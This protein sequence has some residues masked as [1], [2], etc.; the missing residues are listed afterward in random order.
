MQS[1]GV[2]ISARN[3][4]LFELRTP[5]T[6]VIGEAA[7][8]N[9]QRPTEAVPAV[10]AGRALRF[11]ILNWSAWTPERETRAA[12]C[13]WAGAS[14][15][16][17][18]ATPPANLPML[19]RRR[20]SPFGQRL[21][22][23]IN[24]CAAGLPPARYVLSTRHGELARALK[25]L[26]AIEA[27]EL[28]S[29][30]DFSMSIHHALLGILSIHAGN[31]LGHTALSAGWDSFA[32][33]LLEA[34]ACIAER[35]EEPVIL[36]HAD[37][38]LPQDYDAFREA[39]DAALPLVVAIALGRP[40]GAPTNDVTLEPRSAMAERPPTACMATDFLKFLLSDAPRAHAIG[41]RAQWIWRRVA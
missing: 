6:M 8:R 39:D 26:D 13:S 3:L 27:D 19:L 5:D 1:K 15:D 23:A 22:E 10:S 18:N 32:N 33:G 38:K 29:P 41:R 31:R 37:D 9:N 34:A 40:G 12:W 14:H 25:A 36:V 17:T 16:A 21:V 2:C 24:A 11:S 35:P 20:L 7:N 30:T 28:P 4:T